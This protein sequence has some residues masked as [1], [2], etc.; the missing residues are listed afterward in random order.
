MP[1]AV[2]VQYIFRDGE[3]PNRKKI[4]KWAKT[5]LSIF[6]DTAEVTIRV[7]DENEST[8]LN[9]RWRNINSPTN[10]LS[11]AAGRTGIIETN[12]L[13]DIVICAPV[14]RREAEEQNKS[15]EAH[16]A[17]MVVH[18]LLHLLG[19][20]HVDEQDTVKMESMEIRILDNLGYNNPYH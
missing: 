2:D 10:V 1:F 13:G 14:V 3:T 15:Y 19:F 5:T 8:D 7:V 4:Y 16:W 9:S 6:R 12:M 18:G 17:H 11:F 20:D